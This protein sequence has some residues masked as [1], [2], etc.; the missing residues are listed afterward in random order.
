MADYAIL[1]SD[2]NRS[3]DFDG[4]LSFDFSNS[5]DVTVNPVESPNGFIAINKVDSP[6][7]INITIGYGPNQQAFNAKLFEVQQLQ[8]STQLLDIL[9]P[10]NYYRNFTIQSVNTFKSQTHRINTI[11]I[12]FQEI[13]QANSTITT[14][15]YSIE[16]VKNPDSSATTN[17]GKTQEE[18]PT[19]S[20]QSWAADIWDLIIGTE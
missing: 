17:T 16:A 8:R 3:L 12:V 14:S 4:T 9:T 7:Q 5:S 11:N 18:L 20:D 2:Q 13:R 15:E 10:D 6:A 19:Q 1:Y